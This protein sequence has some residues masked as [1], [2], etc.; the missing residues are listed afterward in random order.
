MNGMITREL[1]STTSAMQDFVREVKGLGMA[2]SGMQEQKAMDMRM[3]AVRSGVQTDACETDEWKMLARFLGNSPEFKAIPGKLEYKATSTV[4]NQADA[5]VLATGVIYNRILTKMYDTSAILSEC[6]VIPVEGNLAE[7]PVEIDVP[8][9]S[10]AGEIET[11][12]ESKVSLGMVNIPVN[13]LTL[14]KPVSNVLLQD[15]NV[16][17]FEQYIMDSA[18]N[19]IAAGI[20]DALVKGN[21]ERQPIGAFASKRLK[22]I[23]SGAAT[24]ITTDAILEAMQSVPVDALPNGK[25]YMSNKTFWQIVKN[26]GKDSNYVNLPLNDTVRPSILGHEVK[27][28]NADDYSKSGN[29]CAIFGDM[30]HA[31][32]VVQRTG[33]EFNKNPYRKMDQGIT[34]F[35]FTSRIGGDLV[36][37]ESVIGIKVGA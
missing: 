4:A 7:V 12:K 6:N 20:G 11:R 26:F 23:K 18:G 27:F 14:T 10:W 17:S 34:E 33:L 2:V 31:Y 19:A 28:V 32:T 15:S 37:P 22:T 25:W 16:V 9:T 29:I 30:R 1:K 5:G 13:T 36:M 21:G 35:Y 8:T 24:D 3:S